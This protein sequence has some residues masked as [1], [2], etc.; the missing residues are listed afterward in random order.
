[1]VQRL[2]KTLIRRRSVPAVA[3]PQ[4]KRCVETLPLFGDIG[5]LAEAI[6]ELDAAAAA[7]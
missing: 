6:G 5:E 3:M 2:E 1:M 7:P 4:R